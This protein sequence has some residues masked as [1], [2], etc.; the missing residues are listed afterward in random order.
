MDAILETK[1]IMR[2]AIK[3]YAEKRQSEITNT[4][5]KIYT[6]SEKAT[7]KYKILNSFNDD[8]SEEI[9]LKQLMLIPSLDWTGAS[10]KLIVVEPTI[11]NILKRLSKEQNKNVKSIS[12]FVATND[13][14][15]EQLKLI[16]C[17]DDKPLKRLK[18]TDI[19]D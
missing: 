8:F 12:V 10:M 1:K 14:T 15:A 16:L 11:K 4:Q 5:I 19:L 17:I 6:D 2:N 18:F 3:T 7:P 9:T 13:V